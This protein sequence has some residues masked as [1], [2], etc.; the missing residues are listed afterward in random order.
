MKEG[1]ETEGIKM[2]SKIIN[3]MKKKHDKMRTKYSL[4]LKR[5]K[6]LLQIHFKMYFHLVP[7]VTLGDGNGQP[8]G[9]SINLLGFVHSYLPLMKRYCCCERQK[10]ETKATSTKT[11]LL[12]AI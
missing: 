4:I 7:P 10:L 2:R 11:S 6:V 3:R 5:L 12:K 9:I 8:S 1:G